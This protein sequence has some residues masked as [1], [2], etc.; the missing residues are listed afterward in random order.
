MLSG[1]LAGEAALVMLRAGSAK[2]QQASAR[3][4]ERSWNLLRGK[5]H[6]K[7]ARVKNA[8][9]SIPDED[10]DRGAEALA[11]IP[12]AEM[13]MSKIFRASLSRFPRLVWAMRHLM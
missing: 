5:Q 13:T 11:A 7:L 3:Y 9:R 2:Q 6:Q 10:Y 4:Y 12:H 8:L 1:K